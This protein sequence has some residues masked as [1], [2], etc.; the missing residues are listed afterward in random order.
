[1]ITIPANT[2]P[3]PAPL[4]AILCQIATRPARTMADVDY[5][6]DLILEWME[7]AA[8]GYPGLDLVVFPECSFQGGPTVA[9]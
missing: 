4:R 3:N 5:N 8:S 7:R 1:M 2:S 9:D 6:T